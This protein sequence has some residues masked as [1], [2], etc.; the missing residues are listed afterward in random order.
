MLRLLFQAPPSCD[1]AQTR[2]HDEGLAPSIGH[3]F[4]LVLLQE[5]GCEVVR[6]RG[7]RS[8]IMG[9]NLPFGVCE[10]VTVS[11]ERF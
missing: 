7:P 10:S 2:P 1:S 8:L 6:I 11:L 3:T 9:R 5:S 4:S